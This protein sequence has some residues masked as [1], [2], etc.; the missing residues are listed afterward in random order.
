MVGLINVPLK[1]TWK[2]EILDPEN[3]FFNKPKII[4][5]DVVCFSVYTTSAVLEAAQAVLIPCSFFMQ[6]VVDRN[7]YHPSD[8]SFADIVLPERHNEE[9]LGLQVDIISGWRDFWP[10]I[11]SKNFAQSCEM[12]HSEYWRILSLKLQKSFS[13][14]RDWNS[15]LR[16]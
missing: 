10:C 14:I 3:G 9:H 15:W 6:R 4:T 12:V 1:A 16:S 13:G 8:D 5:L 11:P 7:Q 2:S